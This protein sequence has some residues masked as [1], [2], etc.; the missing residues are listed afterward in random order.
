MNITCWNFLVDKNK[1]GNIGIKTINIRLI[2]YL[3]YQIILLNISKTMDFD[4]VIVFKSM[5]SFDKN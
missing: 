2:N 5:F 4:S 3:K 1:N